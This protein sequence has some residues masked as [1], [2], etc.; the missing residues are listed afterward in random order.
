M[1]IRQLHFLSLG[2]QF[3]F[4]RRRVCFS[5]L[6]DLCLFHSLGFLRLPTGMVA[7][8]P[9]LQRCRQQP[10]AFCPPSRAYLTP[11][12]HAGWSFNILWMGK[13]ESNMFLSSRQQPLP[14]RIREGLGSRGPDP[15][16]RLAA[17]SPVCGPPP[18]FFSQLCSPVRISLDFEMKWVA[19]LTYSSLS[20]S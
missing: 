16:H 2:A 7:V 11:D 3:W 4:P 5:P 13:Q 10:Q 18:N 1:P 6:Q 9:G 14:G 8:F 12:S 19:S 15:S 17:T 20:P